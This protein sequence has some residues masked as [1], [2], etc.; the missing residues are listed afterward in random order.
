M[1]DTDIFKYAT[2]EIK[3]KHLWLTKLIYSEEGMHFGRRFVQ[4][5]DTIYRY[6]SYATGPF[7]IQPQLC[8]ICDTAIPAGWTVSWNKWTEKF[9]KAES[10]FLRANSSPNRPTKPASYQHPMLSSIAPCTRYKHERLEAVLPTIGS[11]ALLMKRYH[12]FYRLA[13]NGYYW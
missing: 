13:T 9:Y 8:A 10:T 2:K 12:S 11:C 6:G 3:K 5:N 1:W 4:L 7:I